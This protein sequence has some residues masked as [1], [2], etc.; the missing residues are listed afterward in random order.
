[1][2]SVF[3]YRFPK[4]ERVYELGGDN[5]NRPTGYPGQLDLNPIWILIDQAPP[6]FFPAR[7]HLDSGMNSNQSLQGSFCRPCF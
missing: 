2:E 1:M 7:I 5:P 3:R 4:R 6:T